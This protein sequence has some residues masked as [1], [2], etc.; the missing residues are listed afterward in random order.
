ME[1]ESRSSTEFR[2]PIRSLVRSFDFEPAT[3][4]RPPETVCACVFCDQAGGV[5]A[6]KAL[7]NHSHLSL[8][9]VLTNYKMVRPTLECLRPHFVL[10]LLAVAQAI[11]L[12]SL[13][14]KTKT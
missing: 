8:N 14:C 9:R 3:V 12:Q 7:Q 5:V 10:P 2:S 13:A 6:L 11:S 1:V 4:A